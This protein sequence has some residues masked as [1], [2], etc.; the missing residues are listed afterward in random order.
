[1]LKRITGWFV[2]L[3][4]AAIAVLGLMLLGGVAAGGFYAYRAYTYVQHDNDF[5]L[6]CH[7]MQDPYE[8]FAQSAHRGLGCKACHQPTL[9]QRSTMALTQI[10]QN[11][12]SLLTHAEV[13]S[14]RCA[15]CHIDGDPEKWLLISQSAG[16]RIHLESSDSALS[17]LECV[18]CH[19]TSLHEFA[20][21]DRTCSQSGCHETTEIRLG[22]MGALTI[23]CATCHEFGAPAGGAP[24]DSVALV[25]RPQREECLGCHAMRQ[26]ASSFPA[27]VDDPHGGS[28]GSCHQPHEQTTPA[29]A[30]ESCATAGCHS[31]VE[32]ITPFH[33]GLQQ[34]ALAD[35]LA[36]HQAHA[37]HADQ[38]CTACHTTVTQPGVVAAHAVAGG[39]PDARPFRHDQHADVVCTSCHVSSDSHGA[40]VVNSYAQC[41]SCHHT[42]ATAEPCAQCH[43]PESLAA[44]RS[45]RRT[46]TFSVGTPKQRDMPFDHRVHTAVECSSCHEAG[47]ARSAA[48][49]DC[50]S[51][52]VE[53]H[54]TDNNCMACHAP[55][56]AGA[57][58]LSAHLTCGGAGCHDP[59]PFQPVPRTRPFC[60]SC[61]QD[62]ID[63]RPD[64]DCAACHALPTGQAAGG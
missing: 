51:C 7:L 26:L 32:E 31:S 56:A 11:P 15:E 48:A 61:H 64:G 42:G 8:R 60:L 17:R 25:M 36:C 53:H 34:Q 39:A 54:E 27:A 19:S 16:H 18:G 3:T 30:V 29:Q 62:L 23:H 45:V 4:P 2:K 55:P 44:T 43:A 46:L 40:V 35:C 13:P 63:H 10:L 14:E 28:C 6:S 50:T 49:T 21:S 58:E 37:F 12:D 5:C 33:R 52:H 47:V 20:A 57:H 59:N 9:T 24:V 38:Q 1:V 22:G 41:Q